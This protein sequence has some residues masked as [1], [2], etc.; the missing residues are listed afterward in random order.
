MN[1]NK[2]ILLLLILIVSPIPLTVRAAQPV[3]NGTPGNLRF[4]YGAWIASRPPGG[5]LQVA[6]NSRLDWV[7]VSFD[8][9]AAQPH[10]YSD[11]QWGALDAIFTDMVSRPLALMISI[12]NAPDWAMRASGPDPK[13]TAKIAA[14][15]ARRYE[16]IPLAIALFPE[17]NTQRGWGAPPSPQAYAA[18]FL[19]TQRAVQQVNPKALLVVG[20]LTPVRKTTSDWSDTDFL[21]GLYCTKAAEDFSIIGVHLPPIG[22][23]PLTNPDTTRQVA[24]RHYET[25]RAVM[26]DNGHAQ[27]QIWITRLT[28]DSRYQRTQA[29][30]AQWLEGAYLLLRT[31]LFIGTAF[32]DGL[33]A[34]EGGTALLHSRGVIHP[35]LQRLT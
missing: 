25:V 34:P 10:A 28:W 27:G 2:V 19:A 11:V 8:W 30:Q 21:A 18:L 4:G 31:Q 29:Q 20:G 13:A 26:V 12:T 15:L 5:D 35:G 23:E 17:A 24:L 32:F 3:V 22:A 9:R 14:Q 7:A 1:V 33:T 16:R 6:E